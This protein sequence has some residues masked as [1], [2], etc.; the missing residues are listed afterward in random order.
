MLEYFGQSPIIV[1]SS[2]LL[3]TTSETPSR[4]SMK[5]FS[6]PIRG[7]PEER[8]EA[9]EQAVRTVYASTMNEDALAYRINRGLFDR[10]EQMAIL[11]QRDSGDRHKDEFFPHIAGV[12]NSSNLYVWDKSVD[13][14]AGMLRLVF[15]L[16][17]G[18]WTVRWETMPKSSVWTI[19]C[20]ALP[21]TAGISGNFPSTARM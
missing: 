3:E 20:A 6:A 19:P 12:G 18:R 16:A 9:F 8:Y 7:T 14:S 2:S 17:P 4:E 13:M 10:D 5:A 11:V 21:S 1:R 15:G